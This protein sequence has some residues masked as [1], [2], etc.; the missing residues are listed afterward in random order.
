[1][2]LLTPRQLSERWNIP[3][4]TL[5]RWRHDKR[6]VPYIK[7]EQAVR[8]RLEDVE[9]YEQRVINKGEL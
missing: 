2:K 4:K 8:Y 9:A 7:L 5:E 3:V 6:G 1:M